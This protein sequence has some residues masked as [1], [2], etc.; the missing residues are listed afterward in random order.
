MRKS[1]SKLKEEEEKKMKNSFK[2]NEKLFWKLCLAVNEK[3]QAYLR[4]I[5]IT[6]LADNVRIRLNNDYRDKNRKLKIQVKVSKDK[7]KTEEKKKMEYAFKEN[8]KLFY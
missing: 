6:G 7:I 4:K 5:N 8:K 2:G 3:E 1:Q